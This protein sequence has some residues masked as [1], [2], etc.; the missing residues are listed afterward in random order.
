M[1]RQTLADLQKRIEYLDDQNARLRNNR[2]EKEARVKELEDSMKE[3]T[4]DL[5]EQVRWL[6]ALVSSTF[7]REQTHMKPDGTVLEKTW[8]SPIEETT[9][10]TFPMR[11]MN[12]RY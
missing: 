7:A 4:K 6:R 12:G 3:V 1:K 8:A 2:D 5:A 10:R 11:G 9:Y